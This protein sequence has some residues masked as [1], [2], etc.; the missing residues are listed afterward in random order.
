M[1]EINRLKAKYGNS[2]EEILEYCDKKEERLLKLQDYD[3]YLAQLQ[4]KV[5]ET[6]AEVKH[7]SNQLSLLRK[8]EAVKLAEAIR[9]GLRDLN[10]LDT[11]FEIVFRELGTYTVQG[12][13]EVEIYDFHE[14]RRTGESARR[15]C[16][17][18]RAVKNHARN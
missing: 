9:K 7:Y 13:D 10:F 2:I 3:A 18:R 11:Q 14:S 5:E 15:C 1:N 17:G 6:E 4:K 16:I 8:E 12:T